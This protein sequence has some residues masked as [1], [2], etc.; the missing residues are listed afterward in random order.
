MIKSKLDR[1]E[2][3]H[4]DIL[5]LFKV[6]EIFDRLLVRLKGIIIKDSLPMWLLISGGVTI[7]GESV[8]V[9]IG[10]PQKK[11]EWANIEGKYKKYFR[12]YEY[13][14]NDDDLFEDK[15]NVRVM[16]AIAD[17]YKQEQEIKDAETKVFKLHKQA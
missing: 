8:K 12:K 4:K 13:K 2:K 17:I 14:F 5:E 15:T 11:I 10:N 3:A 16:K 6:D 9:L 1:V 7:K